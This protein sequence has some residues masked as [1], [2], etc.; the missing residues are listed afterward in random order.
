VTILR[1]RELGDPVLREKGRPV[2]RFDASLKRLAEDMAETMYDAPGVGLAANQ[3]GQA[4]RFFVWD[5]QSEESD[6]WHAVANP[7]LE[8]LGG[9]EEADE[10]CLSVPGLYFPTKRVL[11]VRL[12]G[13]DLDGIPF[14]QEADGWRARIFQHETDHIDGTVYVDRLEG[15]A[16][17]DWLKALREREAGLTP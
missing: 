7:Q 15:D 4:L 14:E 9:E 2:E 8:Y 5:D 12:S 1:I 11:R 13:Q 3:I 16:R 10:G 17:K 6:G